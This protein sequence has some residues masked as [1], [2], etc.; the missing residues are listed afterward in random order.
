MRV[1]FVEDLESG[2]AL[3]HPPAEL[4]LRQQYSEWHHFTLND[5]A[6]GL[7][8]IFNLAMSGNVRDPSHAR[9]GVSLAVYERGRGWHGTMALHPF[10]ATRATP[11]RLD[12]SIGGNA[13]GYED[14]R[15]VVRG[16][17]KDGSV[18]LDATWTPRT[19]SLRVD[20]LGGIVNTF[21]LPSLAVDG[22]VRIRGREYPL[23]GATG[24]HD[25]NWGLWDW[26]GGLGWNWGYVIQV[27][28]TRRSR[29]APPLSLV[30]GR[31]SSRSPGAA[32]S[33]AALG[34]WAGRRCTQIFVGDAVRIGSSGTLDGARV[35]RIPGVMA[36]LCPGQPT[37]IPARMSIHAG[38]G[39]D[40]VDVE[41]ETE[42]A[43]Q[44]LIPRPGDLGHTTIT[45]LVGRYSVRAVLDGRVTEFT[46]TGFA[47]IA[48]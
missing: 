46:Y 40:T 12:L 20:R 7:Y 30:F 48:R 29:Q 22:T 17:L 13:V 47:E 36:L 37:D 35:P 21:I 26:G 33:D 34:V 11:G 27:P 6:H 2:D 41:L 4:A 1:H 10:E 25:H 32:A 19:T 39:P 42:A 38:E 15:Y 16:A 8:G 14:G 31:V 24:Y 3:S 28:A 5:D 23:Q 43:M 45:E 9:A 18:V 44:F